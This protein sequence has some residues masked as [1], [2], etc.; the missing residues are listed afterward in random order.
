MKREP[1]HWSAHWVI[2][3]HLT[4]SPRGEP[5]DVCLRRWLVAGTAAIIAQVRESAP[6]ARRASLPADELHGRL[7][8]RLDVELLV[9]RADMGPDRAHADRKVVGDFLVHVALGQQLQD[10]VFAV[11]QLLDAR[12]GF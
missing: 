11:G 12:S 2:W 10:F 6:S 7:R 9:N 3:D 4:S 8:P 1:F 5:S